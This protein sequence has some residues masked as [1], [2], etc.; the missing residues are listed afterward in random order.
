MPEVAPVAY[1]E[2]RRPGEA[3]RRFVGGRAE[4]RELHAP[5]LEV[6]PRDGQALDEEGE[7]PQVRLGV[8]GIEP[9]YGEHGQP[10]IAGALH[11]ALEGGVVGTA[12]GGLHPVQHVPT[13]A[14]GSIVEGA[15]ARL[16]GHEPSYHDRPIGVAAASRGVFPSVRGYD[17]RWRAP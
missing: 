4:H 12:L 6:A 2:R 13:P 1:E 16:V 5:A 15:Q 9:E 7:V 14:D 10:E 3:E 17:G 8:G 11:G